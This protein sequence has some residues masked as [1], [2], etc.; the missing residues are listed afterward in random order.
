MSQIETTL[1]EMVIEAAAEAFSLDLKAEDIVIEMPKDRD[2]GDYSTNI[3]MRLARELKQRPSEIA[4]T[5]IQAFKL[6][7]YG[8]LKAEIAGPG[9]INL[10]MDKTVLT[11]VVGQVLAAG[12]RYGASTTED[13]RRYNLEYVSANP[14]GDLH[15][16]HARGAANGDSNAR[17]MKMAG[18]DVTREYYMNDAGLQIEKMAR[19]LQARY[20]QANG[21]D[22]AVPEDGYHG[23]DLIQ[24]GQQLKEEVQ[25]QYISTDLEQ[26]LD[27]FK[28]YGLEKETEKLRNDLERFRV[29]FDVFTSEKSLYQRDL[30]T[31]A[32]E[33][34]VKNNVTYEQ[35][36]ATWLRSTAF[37]DDKDR[38]LVR[39]DGN[40]T[41][42][43]PDIAYHLDKKNRG[44]DVLIDFFGADHHGYVTRLKAGVQALGY[45]A[46]DIRVEINQMAR[47]IKDGEEYKL[48]K[49]SGKSIT[50]KDLIEEAGPDS[51]RYFFASRAADTQMDFD[52]DLAVSK[53]NDNPVYY[54]QY[55]HA[56]MCSILTQ[57]HAYE[58]AQHFE[59]LTHEKESEL[60][61]HIEDFPAV[62]RDAAKQLQP[63]R[64]CT[65]I[66]KLA[67][68][69]HSFY[70]SCYVVDGGNVELTKQRL[71]LVKA[72]QITLSNALNLIGV[73][74]PEKM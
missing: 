33:Q 64:V 45:P 73:S 20:Y 31:Q 47:M 6:N 12:E 62:I 57:G 37:G 8:V 26:H 60:L 29:S 9:F 56:R 53:S 23:P 50:L 18:Y 2:H 41:Y 15:P 34:L 21:Q 65:Y 61:K 28:A 42:I 32:L 74:A 71:A 59:M 22:L 55:A 24:I 10:F 49:R 72:C 70:G 17:I 11:K 66:Q 25:D 14:T 13:K 40:Y 19:S 5:L 51:V 48:S 27:F 35:D 52:I 16:G 36:G 44:F 68:L 39:S 43:M 67:S 38:V 46:E 58:L 3:A 63:H 7:Q 30:V 69:F 4:N 54:A 1:K